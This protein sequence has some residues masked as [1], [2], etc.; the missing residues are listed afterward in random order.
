MY[1]ND[2]INF[3]KETVIE[4]YKGFEGATDMY[5]EKAENMDDVM[6]ICSESIVR[7]QDTMK[8]MA[9]GISSISAAMTESADGISA[10]TENISSLV[11]SISGIKEDAESNNDGCRYWGS[12][13][14]CKD[15]LSVTFVL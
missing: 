14:L 9:D 4:D 8:K 15:R 12:Q 5:Y 1:A 10:A 11:N 7:L 2:L 3:M 13:R 6:T